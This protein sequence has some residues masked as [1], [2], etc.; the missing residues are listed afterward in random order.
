M[1]LSELSSPDSTYSP[2]KQK[3]AL[4]VTLTPVQR[5][6]ARLGEAKSVWARPDRRMQSASRQAKDSLKS[7]THPEMVPH[8]RL[9]PGEPSQLWVQVHNH[10]SDNW[11]FRLAIS[12]SIPEP[13]YK[14]PQ[15]A[16]EQAN[17]PEPPQET[18][19]TYALRGREELQRDLEN[20]DVSTT[21]EL[22]F[23]VPKDF[24][25]DHR[26]IQ[27][28]QPLT[29]DYDGFIQIYARR[30]DTAEAERLMVTAPFRAIVRSPSRYLNYLPQVYQEV[31]FIGRLLKIFEESFDPSVETLRGLWAYLD[32]RTSPTALLPFLAH[33][34]GWPTTD[35][36][37]AHG[38]QHHPQRLRQLIVRAMEL[39][40]YRGT[41]KGLKL[42]LHLY[43]GLP[44]DNRAI[45]IENGADPG[46]KIGEARL[47]DRNTAIISSYRKRYHFRVRL[48][49]PGAEQDDFLDQKRKLIHTI[50]RQEKPAFCTYDLRI[51]SSTELST[52]EA[53]S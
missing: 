24:F 39:Y 49:W 14:T 47:G 44:N 12:P 28:R 17:R 5:P 19:R 31:D 32:A 1:Y 2:T 25:E 26:A 9:C 6:E 7:L 43:L 18:P 4:S 15:P 52:E 22:S 37:W 20:D 45:Q 34:V 27:D 23:M 41:A 46:F 35:A 51:E 36:L 13:W 53:E 10:C 40:R 11:S 48:R 42:Y 29:I 3:R 33:W 38:L 21:V 50:I 30:R 8:L 16:A